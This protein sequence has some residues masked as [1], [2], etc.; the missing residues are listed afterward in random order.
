MSKRAD[1]N[2]LIDDLAS[3]DPDVRDHRAL[4][5][6][7]GGIQ[8]GEYD[9]SAR[10]QIATAMLEH[11]RHPQIQARTFAPLILAVLVEHGDWKDAWFP[12]V[13]DWYLAEQDLRGYDHDLGWLHAVAHGADFFG[14]CGVA[15]RVA[16]AD[17]LNVL[18][19]RAVAPTDLAWADMEEIRVAL[20][21]THCLTDPALDTQ[22]AI[23]WVRVVRDGLGEPGPTG[24]AAAWTNTVR[25]LTALHV[26]LGQR[27]QL[28]GESVV[29][30]LAEPVREQVART[31]AST[32][33][34]FW[35]TA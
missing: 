26:A 4:G 2:S 6:L 27:V 14:A 16:A 25:M 20:A 15:R 34:W 18:A 10:A 32:T 30:P 1:L 23:A 21:M 5:A 29:I 13:R 3:A 33:P 19:A 31:L 28:N 7:A 9:Q 12:A 8:D 35:Q 24:P 22:G 17:L 11:L